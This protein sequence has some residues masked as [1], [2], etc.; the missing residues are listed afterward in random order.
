MMSG[1][2]GRPSVRTRAGQLVRIGVLSVCLIATSHDDRDAVVLA[3]PANAARNG[4]LTGELVLEPP[5]LI[6]L[7]FEWLIQGACC[8]VI[9]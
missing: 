4:V 7:G 8:E 6:N 5:T 3:Q 1:R 9:R 2:K